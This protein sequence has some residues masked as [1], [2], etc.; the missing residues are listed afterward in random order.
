[1]SESADFFKYGRGYALYSQGM[2]DVGATGTAATKDSPAI[3]ASKAVRDDHMIERDTLLIAKAIGAGMTMREYAA[4]HGRVED[5]YRQRANRTITNSGYQEQIWRLSE[6][7]LRDHRKQ[8]AQPLHYAPNR[9]GT[10]KPV[11][12]EPGPHLMPP[13]TLEPPSPSMAELPPIDF[14]EFWKETLQRSEVPPEKWEKASKSTSESSAGYESAPATKRKGGVLDQVQAGL[15]AIGIAEPTPFADG[16]NAGISAVRAVTDRKNAGEHLR[17][18]GI[19]LVSAAVPYIGDLAKFRKY[20]GVA[21]SGGSKISNFFSG[22]FGGGGGRRAGNGDGPGGGTDG[23]GGGASLGSA[24]G[25]LGKFAGS[26]GNLVKAMPPVG[27]VLAGVVL[28][29][30]GFVHWLENTDRASR[31]IIEDNRALASL[32]GGVAGAYARLDNQRLLRQIERGREV[33]GPLGR[34][35]SA[36]SR[37]EGA[38]QDLTQPFAKAMIDIQAVIMEVK[39]LIVQGIDY[40]EPISELLQQWYGDEKSLQGS[41]SAFEFSAKQAAARM[42]QRK[43]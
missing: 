12:R 32:N 5:A 4:L 8:E 20:G 6:T 18:A 33:S 16:I 10:G 15:D 40:I 17:N 23:Q 11:E 31:K 28:G 29:I 9:D 41:R 19:S 42:R 27:I 14:A 7:F 24:V 22:M 26:I 2:T 43:L 21:G 13:G 36:Q 37:F 1:M 34:L 3:T 38:R 35:T 25:L 30:K 39:T